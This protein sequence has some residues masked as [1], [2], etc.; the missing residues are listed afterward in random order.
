[1][2]V[3]ENVH[4]SSIIDKFYSSFVELWNIKKIPA[5]RAA[6]ILLQINGLYYRIG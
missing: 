6:G 5:A 4:I 1:M 2:E 3:Y